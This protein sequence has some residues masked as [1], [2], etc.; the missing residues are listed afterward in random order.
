MAVAGARVL[1]V[2]R[3]RTGYPDGVT[4][5]ALDLL[6]PGS[7]DRVVEAA[8][9]T[10]GQ[11]LDI[12][13][14]NAGVFA[15]APIGDTPLD[16]FDHLVALNLT[17]PFRLVRAFLAG[18][19][20]R[21]QGHI[22]TIGSVADHVA[23]RGNGAYAAAKFGLRG[24][25]EVLRGELAGSGVRATLVSPA[26]VGTTLWDTLAAATRADFPASDQM[27]RAEDVAQAV[28]FAVTRPVGVSVD[29][30]RMAR[31]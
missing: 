30:I 16:E 12:L 29:E 31:A 6:A 4:S 1:G 9:R 24:L 8:G 27:L 19:Q 7:I 20:A 11:S 22:V 21:G 17:V 10:F 18:M 13:V 2:S 14:N 15:V 5:V 28:L 23:F 26:A 25:H 3:S